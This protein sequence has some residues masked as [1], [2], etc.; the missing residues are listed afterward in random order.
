MPGHSSRT[1]LFKRSTN[2][3][4]EASEILAMG[5]VA[6]EQLF[7]LN[8][9]LV[10]ILAINYSTLMCFSERVVKEAKGCHK[11]YRRS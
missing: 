4:K 10:V 8:Q 9:Y 5:H 3:S 6:D 2:V 7:S 11:L 1:S